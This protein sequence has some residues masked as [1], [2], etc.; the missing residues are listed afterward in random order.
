MDTYNQDSIGNSMF[1]NAKV[2]RD[3][4]SPKEMQR[5]EIRLNQKNPTDSSG[6]ESRATDSRPLRRQSSNLAGYL[7]N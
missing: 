5:T 3:T 7:S 2:T 4:T 1:S 6:V